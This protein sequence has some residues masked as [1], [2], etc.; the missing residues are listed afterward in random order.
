MEPEIG[1]ELILRCKAEGNPEAQISWFKN[2]KR[3]YRD[4][5]ISFKKNHMQISD[6]SLEDN[7][8]YSC[9]AINDVGSVNSTEI[10]AL[11][12]SGNKRNL[13]I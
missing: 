10:F 8:V 2:G 4:E 6:V 9:I 11:R 13:I 5:R 1:G 12:L 7:G 3:L